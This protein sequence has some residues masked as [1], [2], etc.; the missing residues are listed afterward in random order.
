[1]GLRE[2]NAARTR[3]LI[4]DAA[5][6]LFEEH[7]YDNTSL[8]DIAER[9]GVSIS[10]L[11]RYFRTKDTLVLEPVAVRGQMSEELLSRPA[12]EPI[13]VALGHAL[14]ALLQTPRGNPTRLRQI[15]ELLAGS[16]LLRSRVRDEL[17]K[18]RVLLQ[19]AIGKRLG[20][21]E[22]DVYCAMTARLALAVFEMAGTEARSSG[23]E[24]F[25][26]KAFTTAASYVMDALSS[27]PP[28]LPRAT[29]VDT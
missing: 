8:E 14:L 17:D 24:S 12:G 9:A 23:H 1:M 26:E 5:F 18:E 20:R 25:D 19:K 13:D 7:G 4:L 27:D 28:T 3:E 2:L 6:A 22:D 29:S 10:T 15:R 21:S 11:Y 16:P